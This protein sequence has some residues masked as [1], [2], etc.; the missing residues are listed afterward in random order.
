MSKLR[1]VVI[2]TDG[3]CS[4]NPGPGGWGAL[5]RYGNIEREL[6]GGAEYTT[7]NR[8]ELQAVAEALSVLK[9]P[10]TVVVKSD[11]RYVVT[12]LMIYMHDW[13]SRGWKK[14]D[15]T[16]VKHADLWQKIYDLALTHQVVP[17]WVKGHSGDP[18]NER[19]DVLAKA[20]IPYALAS[21]TQAVAA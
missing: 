2:Y 21:G 19:V 14:S 8:M 15:G 1:N 17:V 5:L 10:C 6:S 4:G 12:S 18:D 9:K 7:N 11:S 16:E 3:S 20:A 13:V